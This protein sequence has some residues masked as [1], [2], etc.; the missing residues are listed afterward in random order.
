MNT[1]QAR[2]AYSITN[3]AL[4]FLDWSE[5][6]KY[7]GWNDQNARV[8]LINGF[9]VV[10]KVDGNGATLSLV[11]PDG[12]EATAD[13]ATGDERVRVA[14]IAALFGMWADALDADVIA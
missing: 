11:G 3:D 12:V 4:D 10:V 2:T 14:M 7:V 8:D 1:R 13:V 5:P 6:V 9:W